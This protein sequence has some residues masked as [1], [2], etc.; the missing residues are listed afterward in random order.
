MMPAQVPVPTDV[1]LPGTQPLEVTNLQANHNC[2]NCHSGYDQ[3]VEPGHNWQGSAMAQAARDPLFWATVAVAEQDFPGAGDLCIRCHSPKAWLDGRSTPTD[4][5]ALSGDDVEG[6]DCVACHRMVNPDGSE[7]TGEQNAPYTAHDGGTPPTGYYGSGMYVINDSGDRFGPYANAASPH[8]S[9]QSLFHRSSD[10]CGTCHDVSNPVTGDLA[11]GN[12][13]QFPLPAGAFSGIAG[14]PVTG[15][16]AFNNFPFQYGVVERTYSEHMASLFPTTPVSSYP[17][18]PAELREGIIEAV[19]QDAQLAGNG[20]DYEDGTQRT[21]TCQSCHMRPAVGKGCSHNNAPV[22]GDIPVHR[23]TGG[24]YWIGE[25]IQYQDALGQLRL[26]GGLDASQN[27]AIDDAQNAARAMLEEA[28][29]LEVTG[30]T[31]RVVN[32]TGHKLISGF[33]EGRRMW[34]HVVW[35]DGNGQVVREDGAYGPMTVTL[36]G[37]PMQ[38]E[39]LLAPGDPHT[40]V[41][42]AKYGITQAWASKLLQLGWP[43]QLP[44]SYH[45]QSGA[46]TATLGDVAA[47]APGE[48]AP[49]F[50]FVLLDTILSDNRIPPYGMA[51]DAAVQRN[52][53]PVP[54]T[55]YGDPGPGGVY[56]HWDVVDLDPPAGAVDADIEL[57]YQPTSW[58]YI[59]FLYLANDGS[60]SY[61]AAEGQKMLDTWLNT[62][63]AA[64]HVMAV[65]VWS[66]CGAAW[67]NYGSGWPGSGGVPGLTLDA[68]PVLGS[69]VVLQVGNVSGQ[70]AAAVLAVGSAP[71]SL[72]TPAG[73]SLLVVPDWL[74]DLS[75]PVGGL[76]WALSM[77]ADPA[78][79]GT[80]IFAQAAHLDPA[81]SHGL[82]FSPGLEV[83]L[84]Y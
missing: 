20:G 13:A 30:D 26:G 7:H 3:T 62:G 29:E 28:A 25:A 16:A 44:V 66:G 52:V 69:T 33:P 59:Q 36:N 5:S 21:F 48:A 68:D 60:V 80:T 11:P 76:S 39:A 47:L 74:A 65:A 61:L 10:L 49:S 14:T 27:A 54:A 17:S 32:L 15:K 57:L 81:A 4:G 71:A 2:L 67:S 56:N 23:F 84:G 51:R 6:V 42:E 22:R 77:P 34:L 31:V 79:C 45:R 73:G 18:L 83:H 70:P 53:L 50:H 55:L 8:T 41:Y 9:V 78:L 46:V 19:W 1:Q 38:V 82:A 12:G 37:S 35:R 63:M 24:N 72:A 58:E 40:H 64:P 43:S 75:L